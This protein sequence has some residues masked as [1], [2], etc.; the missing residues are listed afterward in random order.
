MTF[1]LV[2]L[3]DPHLGAD[4]GGRDPAAALEVAVA[5][6]LALRPVPDAVL[7]T[8]D[9]TEH[10]SD[11]EY[12]QAR[13]LLGRLPVPAHVLPGNHDDR[14]GLR[15]HFDLPRSGDEPVQYAA[16]LG[17]LRL[18]VVDS[19][20]PGH[21]DG[22]LDEERLAWLDTQLTAA[23]EQPTL[24]A[25]HHPPLVSGVP[26]WD[27]FALAPIARHA[28]AEVVTRH[29]QVRRIVGGHVHRAITTQLAHCPV[30]SAPST[31]AQLK[32]TIG[33]DELEVGDDPAGFLVH[34][35]VDGDLVSHV[36]PVQA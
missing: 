27:S 6:V 28:L 24:I 8:G 16:D 7:V 34:A 26:A 11:A 15:R 30:V 10:A 20:R 13:E 19:T 3:S 22:E 36:Q 18:V 35:L 33:A 25:M 14:A 29:A 1:V 9:L 5:S 2:Q 32:L 12:E 4:W 23:P 31:Y 21:D 17:P